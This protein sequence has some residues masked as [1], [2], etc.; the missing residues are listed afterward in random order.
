MALRKNGWRGIA[1][2]ASLEMPVGMVRRTQAGYARRGSRLRLHPWACQLCF[3]KVGL[4]TYIVQV[5]VDAAK[6]VQDKVSNRISA[7]N[8]VWVAVKGLE[9]PR[10][11]GG[12]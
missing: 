1:P 7:L 2:M 8:R 6:V 9:E 10:V 3:V 11:S 4:S 12:C 5:N